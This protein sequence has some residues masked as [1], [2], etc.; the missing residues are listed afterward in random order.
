MVS[1]RE[2]VWNGDPYLRTSPYSSC[3]GHRGRACGRTA[4]AVDETA[5]PVDEVGR[6]GD[7]PGTDR[8]E[9]GPARR[10]RGPRWGSDLIHVRGPATAHRAPA[11]AGGLLSTTDGGFPPDSRPYPRPSPVALATGCHRAVRPPPPAASRERRTAISGASVGVDELSD[12]GELSPQLLVRGGLAAYLVAGV[13]HR[14]VVPPAELGADPEERDVGL[15]AHEEHRDLTRHDDRLV[16]LL[17]GQNEL[18]QFR[19]IRSGNRRDN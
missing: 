15:L 18:I 3:G 16:A 7:G 8:C 5:R 4:P 14:G 6:R 10:A 1:G 13:D 9:R 17:S 19:K 12:R 11:P 2:T